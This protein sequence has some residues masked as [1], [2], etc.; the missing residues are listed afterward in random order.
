MPVYEVRYEMEDGFGRQTS[1]TFETVDLLDEAAALTAASGMAA[2][3]AAIS[4]ARILAYTVKQ[5][6]VHSDTVTAGA[7]KD[8]GAILTLR[9]EDNRKDE[10]RV[11]APPDSIF[12]GQGN[13]DIVDALVVAFVANFLTPGGE[14]TFSDGESAT[15]IV[16]G[17]LES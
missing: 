15:E 8:E 13:V 10:I 6:V 4:E 12:D 11:P 9:K 16:S 3:L 17:Y 14:F 7:N 2:D 5:R 1:K